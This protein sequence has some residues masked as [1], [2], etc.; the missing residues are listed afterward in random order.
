MTRTPPRPLSMMNIKPR[1]SVIIPWCNRNE[2]RTSLAGNEHWMKSDRIEVNIVNCG[3]DAT[4]LQ[5]IFGNT[6]EIPYKQIDV[7]APK[8]NK[9]LALNLGLFASSAPTIFVM[10]ADIILNC[11]PLTDLLPLVGKETF[12]TFDRV[13]ESESS[14]PWWKFPDPQVNNRNDFIRSMK[15]THTLEFGWADGTTTQIT[16][17]RADIC[18]NSRFGPGLLMADREHLVTIEGYNSDLRLWGW[19]DNDVELR[20][21]HALS[22]KH[23]YF[24]E[25]THLTHGDE[26]RNLEGKS[27]QQ[28][29]FENFATVCKRYSQG[30]FLGTYS[31]DV[32]A[33]WPRTKR[34]PN[35]ELSET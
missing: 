5:E 11:L 16:S 27:L 19:E 26:T 22:L 33:W 3:G 8:F 12:L 1:L 18:D 28:S 31:S 35:Q 9:S 20:L 7:P 2:L 23:A 15:E 17:Y 6:P 25:A 13:R 4:Q 24:G 29:D 10:D 30:N 32:S 14:S 34:L 21:R